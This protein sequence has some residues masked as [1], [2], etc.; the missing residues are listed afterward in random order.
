M[1]RR[2]IRALCL[3]L[4]GLMVGAAASGV[5]KASAALEHACCEAPASDAGVPDTSDCHGF[6]PL[7]CCHASA[8]PGATARMHAPAMPF[9]AMPAGAALVAPSNA[10]CARAA[11]TPTAR[12][13]PSRLSVVLQL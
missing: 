1:R 9:V 12:D 3:A 6:L 4:L 2:W 13:A 8:L 7:S 10:L 11:A 5:A